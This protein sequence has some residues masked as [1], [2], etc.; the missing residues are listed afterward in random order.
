MRPSLLY[1]KY[2]IFIFGVLCS[3]VTIAQDFSNKGREFWV[4]YG[5]HVSMYNAN[6]TVNTTNGGSQNMVLYFTSDQD[7]NVTVEIPATGWTRSYKVLANQVTTSEIIPKTGSDDAR[8]SDEGKSNKG[9]HIISDV[10]IIAYTHIYN[11]SISGASL[12]FPV[13]T[14]GRDY[15]SVNYTQV[16]NSAYSYGYTY[17][18]ATEDNTNIEIILSANTINNFKGDTIRQTLMKGEIY[19]IFGKLNTTTNPFKGEDLTGTRIRS[20]ATSTSA[21]KRIAVFSG[22]G[23]LSITCTTGSGSA[24]N[25]IQQA[26]PSSAWGR[27]YLTAP[28]NKMPNNF[29]RVVVSNGVGQVTS[30]PA[31]LTDTP[32][33]VP[34]TLQSQPISRLVQPG[35]DVTLAVQATGSA[36]LR[37]QWR[38]AGV[39][40]VGATSSSYVLVSV[41]FA[42]VG[43]YDVVVT[44]AVGN[45]TSA[46]ATVTLTNVLAPEITASP[47]SQ[48]ANPGAPVV[49]SVSAQGTALNYQWRRNGQQLAG[50]TAS[51]LSFAGVQMADAGVSS[52]ERHQAFTLVSASSPSRLENSAEADKPETIQ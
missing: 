49:F 24:D 19:N 45:A 1:I 10:G 46:P 38:K 40:I 30:A 26:F 9:I 12:L 28:T 50:A 2:L 20:V 4:G 5:S 8:I 52:F 35:M 47:V 3:T 42:N 44:N 39:A 6:G 48:S 7:A 32:V 21:C 13:S 18:I 15:Y 27:K 22:S 31:L 36:P 16:S 23:K 14:L 25:Y 11:S 51:T 34:P 17:V 43:S 37:Y 33:P 29:Y 41:Q